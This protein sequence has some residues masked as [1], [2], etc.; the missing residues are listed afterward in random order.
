MLY[1]VKQVAAHTGISVR[2]LHHY[3]Q[4]GLLQPHTIHDNGYRFYDESN[5]E[6]LYLILFYREIGYS[7]QTI[8]QLISGDEES[9]LAQFKKQKEL[10]TLKKAQLDTMLFTLEKLIKGDQLMKQK[11]FVNNEFEKHRAAYAEEAKARYGQSDAYKESVQK[12]STYSKEEWET[13]QKDSAR[14]FTLFA[15]AQHEG[16]SP[17]DDAVHHIVQQW[18]Q[19][20]TTFYYNCTD[21][22]LAGLGE[23]YVADERFTQN[24]DQ[25]GVGVAVFM[26]EAIASFV[27][28]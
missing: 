17:N 5:M 21:E 3:H 27:K 2:T 14:I 19:H 9:V 13:A 16:L 15:T 24:I 8:A 20:I 4:I 7:L 1:S 23:M 6:T 22:I 26:S 18:Q 11:P 12:T 28:K 10:L 25:Y